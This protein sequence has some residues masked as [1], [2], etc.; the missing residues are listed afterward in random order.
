MDES[1]LWGCCVLIVPVLKEFATTV[2]TYLPTGRWY[3]W[4]TLLGT[5]SRGANVTLYAPTNII[6]ILIRG[7]VIIPTQQPAL[8][9]AERLVL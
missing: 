5:E 1:F 6:P 3:D 8:N 9:T 7:G 4:Y 2:D